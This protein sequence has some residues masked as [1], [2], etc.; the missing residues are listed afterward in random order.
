[1]SKTFNKIYVG[2]SKCS[3]YFLF[4]NENNQLLSL[5]Q[6]VQVKCPACKELRAC[7]VS[8]MNGSLEI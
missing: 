7:K 3:G 8:G 6:V 4:V 2:C 5:N 1:M